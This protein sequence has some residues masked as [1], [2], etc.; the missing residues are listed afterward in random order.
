VLLQ[1][2]GHGRYLRDTQPSRESCEGAGGRIAEVAERHEQRRQQDM[3]PLIGFALTHAEQAPLDHL[4]GVGLQVNQQEEQ[5]IFRR[6][7]RAGLI[8]G[9]PAG[10]PGFPI[11]APCRHMRLERSL[12]GRHQR[13][14]FIKVAGCEFQAPQKC[15]RLIN[16]YAI[17]FIP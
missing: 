11:E 2:R 13:L 5:S 7:Q 10:S 4:E 14:K 15:L 3:D 12:E 9:E 6:C 1:R 16:V 17:S 8:H